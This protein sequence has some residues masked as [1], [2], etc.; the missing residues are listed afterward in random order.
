MSRIGLRQRADDFPGAEPDL[1][2]AR[3]RAAECR[4]Q[5]EL[6]ALEINAER[7]PQFGERPL[8]RGRDA[9]GAQDE[10]ANGTSAHAWR[11]KCA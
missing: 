5:V 10:A 3:R 4:V 11:A 8:L 6:V 1:E 9:A 2:A 7:W